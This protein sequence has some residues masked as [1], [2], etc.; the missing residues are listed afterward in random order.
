MHDFA[1]KCTGLDPK[2]DTFGTFYKKKIDVSLTSKKLKV[3]RERKLFLQKTA[4][5]CRRLLRYKRSKIVVGLGITTQEYHTTLEKYRA[6][7]HSLQALCKKKKM[8]FNREDLLAE[9]EEFVHKVYQGNAM[10]IS[11]RTLQTLI[12]KNFQELSMGVT[13]VHKY[14]SK[15]K[16]W[17]KEVLKRLFSPDRYLDLVKV[18]SPL[19]TLN[20]VSSEDYEMLTVAALYLPVDQEEVLT[21]MLGGDLPI[22]L[23]LTEVLR[24]L[25]VLVVVASSY[26]CS[27]KVLA[28]ND[29]KGT[30][31][32]IESEAIRLR[33]TFAGKSSFFKGIV[34]LVEESS[35][36]ISGVQKGCLMGPL[37][38]CLLPTAASAKHLAYQALNKYTYGCCGKTM[39]GKLRNI[40]KVSEGCVRSQQLLITLNVETEGWRRDTS[41]V[42]LDEL[43]RRIT[44]K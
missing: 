11:Y 24:K 10:Q 19:K 21:Q 6:G 22:P 41:K 37:E 39:L 28:E 29:A 43:Y 36:E 18:L 3:Q 26:T 8:R 32:L 34:V 42:L 23:V 40:A 12:K 15:D 44:E 1:S 16:F 20:M 27:Y 17:A 35:F 25:K 5:V 31:D 30:N 9:V 14:F 7:G 2:D 33:L 38:I 13:S 4:V